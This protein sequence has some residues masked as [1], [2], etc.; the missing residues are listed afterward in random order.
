MRTA[1]S[2]PGLGGFVAC[3]ALSKRNDDPAKASRPWD[4]V[5]ERIAL[6]AMVCVICGLF[7]FLELLSRPFVR[8]SIIIEQG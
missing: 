8:S 4:T 5:S 6:F 1:F 7:V 3:K 2:L